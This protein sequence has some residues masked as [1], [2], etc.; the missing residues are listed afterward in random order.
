MASSIRIDAGEVTLLVND[1]PS[2]VIK[3][4]PE[5]ILFVERFYSL[6]GGF[7]GVQKK[8]QDRLDAIP[9][10]EESTAPRVIAV[11]EEACD[12]LME[13]IDS[14]FG[15]GTSEAAFAGSKSLSQIEQFFLAIAP[16]VKAKRQDK[17]T[18]Y[19]SKTKKS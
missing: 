8:F 4:N 9:D 18:K 16:Y 19:Q 1:D 6:L 2:R 11:I 14:V 10:N 3:F 17:V 5:D 15:A 12:Y 13:Q 7:E